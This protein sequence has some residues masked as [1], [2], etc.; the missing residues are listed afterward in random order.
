MVNVPAGP[1]VTTSPP[2]ASF[3]NL[4]GALQMRGYSGRGRKWDG[5]HAARSRS[6]DQ[7][8]VPTSPRAPGRLEGKCAA[9][10]SYG[11]RTQPKQQCAGPSSSGDHAAG[12]PRETKP[13]QNQPAG[14]PRTNLTWAVALTQRPNWLLQHKKPDDDFTCEQ[15]VL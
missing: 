9:G 5:R 3:S 7:S 10:S 12:K 14:R 15:C 6:T 4:S 1:T 2:F 8:S 13:A 11:G